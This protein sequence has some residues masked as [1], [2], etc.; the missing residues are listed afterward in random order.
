M[1]TEL[2]CGVFLF[3]GSMRKFIAE[4]RWCAN[5]KDSVRPAGQTGLKKLGGLVTGSRM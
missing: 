5:E 4:E 3:I 1:M 2:T